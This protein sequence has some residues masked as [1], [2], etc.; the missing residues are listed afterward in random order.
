V[1]LNR[2]I[3]SLLSILSIGSLYS[4]EFEKEINE[5]LKKEPRL[6]ANLDSRNAFISSNGV[7]VLGFKVGLLYDDKLAFGL[8]YNQLSSTYRNTIIYQG[9]EARVKL[10]YWYLSPYLEYTFYRDKKWELSIPVQI[11]IGDSYY[12]LVDQQDKAIYNKLVLSYEP[13]ISF[14]YRVLN[15]FGVGMGVGYRLMIIPNRELEERFT[16]PVYMLKFKVYFED[17][18]NRILDL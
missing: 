16:S 2:L 6:I 8:G 3:I 13:A 12:K 5:A 4:Q 17:L 10:A 15:Y 7:R 11:G 18:Y 14:Q 9:E 1:N